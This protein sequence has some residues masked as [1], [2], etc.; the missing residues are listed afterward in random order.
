MRRLSRKTWI[1][2]SIIASLILFFAWMPTVNQ[3]AHCSSYGKSPNGYY[4]WYRLMEDR[5]IPIQRWQQNFQ[6]LRDS[7]EENSVL[8]LRIYCNWNNASITDKEANWIKQGNTLVILGRTTP[9][10]K[11]SF[12]TQHDTPH[13]NIK[14]ETTRRKQQANSTILKD[15]FGAIVWEKQIGKG[16]LIYSTTPYLAANA[17]QNNLSN[18]EFLAKVLESYKPSK[19]LVDEYIHGY[20]N[21]VSKQ[22]ERDTKSE[23]G[24]GWLAY[25]TQTPVILLC[26]QGFII[27]LIAMW[28]HNFRLG[29]KL[30][31]NPIKTNNSKAYIDAL[32]SLLEKGKSRD[33][34]ID[35]IGKEEQLQLQKQLG[36]K[37][38]ILDDQ[39]LI[40]AWVQQTQ[41]P[42]TQLKRLLSFK[43]N[44]PALSDLQLIQWMQQWQKIKN[45]VSK[46][47]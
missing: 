6:S 45:E 9:V 21:Q 4:A 11:A 47:N 18:H 42:A 12:S 37:T 40:D 28:N 35:M 14:I 31:L 8:L 43:S 1:F 24:E 34:V 38:N 41:K 15:E 3:S 10:T 46:N 7:Q 30:Q 39:A 2:L 22:K 20:R 33:F 13:G 27:F 5:D 32:A 17:Y 19:I 25:L 44:K 23:Q 26:I 36:I 29:N 16:Q